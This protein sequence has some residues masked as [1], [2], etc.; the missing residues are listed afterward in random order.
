MKSSTYVSKIQESII[1]VLSKC[2]HY[3]GGDRCP[4]AYPTVQPTLL[5]DKRLAILGV[6]KVLSSLLIVTGK[7]ELVSEFP[8]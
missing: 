4:V 8:A 7:T 2:E 5:K 3:R 6:E 1:K